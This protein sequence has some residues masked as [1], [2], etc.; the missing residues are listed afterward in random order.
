MSSIK[1]PN[2]EAENPAPM[3]ESRTEGHKPKMAVQ[4]DSPPGIELDGEAHVIP[5]E[6]R[7]KEDQEKA[8]GAKKD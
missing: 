4:K 8:R 1:N 2:H 7:T 3:P 6:Q 5:L